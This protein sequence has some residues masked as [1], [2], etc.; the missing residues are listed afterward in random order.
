MP[1]KPTSTPN[2]KYKQHSIL[3]HRRLPA[4]FCRIAILIIAS[5]HSPLASHAQQMLY[6][7][8]LSTGD[9]VEVPGINEGR[10]VHSVSKIDWSGEFLGI[11]SGD[12]SSRSY[13]SFWYPG[14]DGS[15]FAAG[16]GWAFPEFEPVP[17]TLNREGNPPVSPIITGIA[18]PTAYDGN[19]I[20]KTS[21]TDTDTFL[22]ETWPATFSASNLSGLQHW[23]HGFLTPVVSAPNGDAVYVEDIEVEDKQ[24]WLFPD[25][26]V[27]ILVDQGISTEPEAFKPPIPE[28]LK[29]AFKVFWGGIVRVLPDRTTVH[30]SG[31]NTN[32]SPGSGTIIYSTSPGGAITILQDTNG[33]IPTDPLLPDGADSFTLGDVSVNA[34]GDILF[35]AGIGK[36]SEF[37]RR[38]YWTTTP[39]GGQPNLELSSFVEYTL[40]DDSKVTFSKVG[41]ALIAD[42]RDIL[43]QARLE[44]ESIDSVWRKLASGEIKRISPL[45]ATPLP[46]LPDYELRSASIY[47][48]N[49]TG[50]SVLVFE[51][52]GNNRTQF[53]YYL[54]REDGSFILA[55]AEGLPLEDI[56]DSVSVEEIVINE[57]GVL[58]MLLSTR[59]GFAI[60]YHV[61]VARDSN[62]IRP[63]GNKYIWTGGV[64]TSDWHTVTN[65]RSN[66]VDS[67]GAPW[68]APPNSVTAEVEIGIDAVVKLSGQATVVRQLNLLAG[69]LEVETSFYCIDILFVQENA[70]LVQRAFTIDSKLIISS[71]LIIKEGSLSSSIVADKLEIDDSELIVQGGTFTL[72]SDTTLD[73]ATLRVE[74]GT[75]AMTGALTFEGYTPRLEVLD[76]AVVDFQTPVFTFNSDTTIHTE[77]G[78]KITIGQ[79]ENQMPATMTFNTEF[80]EERRILEFTGQG[81]TTFL[82]PFTLS[83]NG[84]IRNKCGNGAI[85]GIVI[86]TE[87]EKAGK[88]RPII[89]GLFENH[90]GLEMASGGMT[91]EFRNYG[92][93][94]ITNNIS[95]NPPLLLDCKNEGTIIQ[96]GSFFYQTFNAKPGSFHQLLNAP[97]ATTSIIPDIEGSPSLLLDQGSFIDARG[98]RCIIEFPNPDTP[99]LL[100]QVNIAN[101]AELTIQKSNTGP[102]KIIEINPLGR[103][104]IEDVTFEKLTLKGAGTSVLSGTVKPSSDSATLKIGT[105]TFSIDDATFVGLQE[106]IIAVP[107]H[108]TALYQ[109]YPIGAFKQ[110]GSIEDT[111]FSVRSFVHASVDTE[112]FFK[113]GVTLNDTFRFEGECYVT[114]PILSGTDPDG[115]GKLW[116]GYYMRGQADLAVAPNIAE[117]VTIPYLHITGP[118]VNITIYESTYVQIQFYS[119]IAGETLTTGNWTIHDFAA[120][121]FRQ[122]GTS[123]T[124][125][126]E[127]KKGASVKLGK[128]HSIVPS[129]GLILDQ[130]KNFAVG[131]K[132]EIENTTLNMNG[133]TLYN[134]NSVIFGPGS[135]LIG[136]VESIRNEV[137]GVIK[138]AGNL[139]I[140]GN[141]T[142]DGTLSLGASP[143]TGIITGDLTLLPGS[144][145]IVE[146]S[147]SDPGTEFDFL[148]IGGTAT[149]AGTLCL[150]LIDEYIPDVDEAFL[151]LKAGS[152]SGSFAKVDQTKMGRERR[153][154]LSTGDE[155]LVLTATQIS[156]GSYDQWRGYFFNETDADDDS[157]SGLAADPDFDGLSNL[158]E[159]LHATRPQLSNS[160]PFSFNLSD[161]AML[162]ADVQWAKDISDYTWDLQSSTDLQNWE[163]LAFTSQLLEE[164]SDKEFIR[165]EA[166][167]NESSVDGNFYRFISKA[168]SE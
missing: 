149:L 87:V 79:T 76:G 97:G 139:N 167:S 156:I 32:D 101:D 102:A 134:N 60:S 12:T 144:E 15:E 121:E 143:G 18:G 123:P 36:T 81:Q 39:T 6:T 148:E 28:Q 26:T 95:F 113:E 73:D 99:N 56:G 160:S 5:G 57:D 118:K 104:K 2:N 100:A 50:R 66:W 74:G 1:D 150:S 42:N 116:A 72:W 83:E 165:I 126:S 163:A 84:I 85:P 17:G 140:E 110:V 47:R 142:T 131:G 65:G 52:I 37:I 141:L 96:N 45:P 34:N 105:K 14:A 89:N 166:A 164:A 22:V 10:T 7:T 64:G 67:L 157:I 43:F 51:G 16:T 27:Q 109:I 106:D 20:L 78:A 21:V 112:I 58:G 146:F 162:T 23:Y 61:V 69:R 91:G 154:D 88:E 152:I 124:R 11:F 128:P 155:G 71:G 19:F 68:D 115:Q 94:L 120:C 108:E 114:A 132:L 90:A 130:Q 153:F 133:Y 9:P 44:G 41:N 93:L 103:L 48:A 136:N 63:A 4:F 119:F 158:S 168:N 55:V 31:Y 53:A 40:M 161:P 92:T 46:G 49:A 159:Y 24:G 138:L 62:D 135:K 147:G 151:F 129:F 111:L 38:T 137:Q 82:V 122:N 25:G 29:G 145:M 30:Y 3:M 59:V 33:D 35:W 13:L 86:D 54:E 77:A 107:T 80:A 8:A 70:S 127:I 98:S 117:T 125:I 75:V